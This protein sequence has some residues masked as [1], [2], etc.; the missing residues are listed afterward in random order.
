MM[1]K[2]RSIR[3]DN[4]NCV[5]NLFLISFIYKY[6]IKS[7]ELNG[8]NHGII[9]N[10][11]I[12]WVIIMIIFFLLSSA[13]FI[14]LYDFKK[15]ESNLS[16]AGDLIIVGVFSFMGLIVWL[17]LFARRKHLKRLLILLNER[18]EEDSNFLKP[19]G[20]K[21]VWKKIIIKWIAILLLFL[22]LANSYAH[23]IHS[24]IVKIPMA[25]SS[26][27]VKI[28]FVLSLL[29]H[30]LL[31]LIIPIQI[32]IEINFHLIFLQL[33]EN[34]SG[35]IKSLSKEKKSLSDGKQFQLIRT[36]FDKI[37]KIVVR[38]D[39]VFCYIFILNFITLLIS[40]GINTSQVQSIFNRKSND[41]AMKQHIIDNKNINWINDKMNQYM[42][43]FELAVNCILTFYYL[44]S[45]HSVNDQLNKPTQNLIELGLEMGQDSTE[46]LH[47][48]QVNNKVTFEVVL[49]FVLVFVLMF[50][51]VFILLVVMMITLVF[52]LALN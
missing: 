2:Q 21:F 50:F 26:L 11:K 31:I 24:I 43:I 25:C 42:A 27:C 35:Y 19:I 12:Q 15:I 3:K 7:D 9:K 40:I 48:H 4:R 30:G 14:G 16:D 39:K 49:V 41:T 18:L 52:I 23:I 8:K 45:L 28:L 5:S 6:F 51:L 20:R 34:L 37:A 33:I 13:S 36:E 32:M 46:H 44:Q 29:M 38:Y 22:F 47:L 17:K 1:S 10:R